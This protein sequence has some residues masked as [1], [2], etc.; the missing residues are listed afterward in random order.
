MANNGKVMTPHVM[1]EV[2]N[3]QDD[4]VDRFDPSVW[5][6]AMEPDTAEL[7]RQ[8]MISVVTDGTARALDDDVENNIVVGGKTGTAQIGTSDSSH[9]WIIGFAGPEGEPPSVAVAVIVEAQEGVSE[10]TGGR[11][12]A[13]IGAAVLA[14]ALTAPTQAGATATNSSQ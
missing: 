2:R 8:A 9:A 7:L 13:P 3:D 10:Q 4:V 5:T 11:V 12:A 6:T 14:Q 1:R